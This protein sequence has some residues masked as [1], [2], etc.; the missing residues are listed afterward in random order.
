ME[1]LPEVGPWSQRAAAVRCEW[2]AVGASRLVAAGDVDVLV[3][4]DVLSFTTAV[5]VAVDRGTAVRP[6]PWRDPRAE[7][8]ADS[9]GAVLA[10]GRGDVTA[11]RPWSLSPAALR[12]APAVPEL[13]LPSPNGSAIAAA[14][15]GAVV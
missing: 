14:A 9:T 11:A 4:V 7:Q 15:S 12:A 2:G 8:L 3:V 10:V 1:A 13:V 5:S 6:A